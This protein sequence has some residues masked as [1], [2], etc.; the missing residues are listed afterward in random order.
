M[1]VL[2][3]LPAQHW[4]GPGF[5]KDRDVER[6]IL[7]SNP[8]I[9]HTALPA[10]FSGNDERVRMSQFAHEEVLQRI[11]PNLARQALDL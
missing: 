9:L 11:Q 5:G 4:R 3:P 7:V 8:A 10:L 1:S 6:L 2:R